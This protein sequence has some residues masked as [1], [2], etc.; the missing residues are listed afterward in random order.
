MNSVETNRRDNFPDM[1]NMCMH[2]TELILMSK[3]C[4]LYDD[5]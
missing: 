1:Q 3:P 5:L 4:Q 2:S